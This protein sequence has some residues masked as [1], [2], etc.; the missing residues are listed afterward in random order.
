MDS[1]SEPK[2][3]PQRVIP[4]ESPSFVTEEELRQAEKPPALFAKRQP[5]A[6]EIGC[7]TGDF[8]IEIARCRPDLNFLAVDI[9]N[10]GCLK[11]CRKIDRNDLTNVRVLRM[12]ACH[13]LTHYLEPASL[14]ALYINCPDPW[15][16]KRHRQRRLVN[17]DFILLVRRS[18]ALTG[19]LFF[20]TDYADYARQVL[21]LFPF[22]GYENCLDQ[23]W[24]PHLEGY[25]YSKYMRRF[26]E[27]GQTLYF[28]HQRK[29]VFFPQD[30]EKEGGQSDIFQPLL[31]GGLS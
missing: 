29:T 15:P 31:A 12:E 25:P 16:K 23:P 24:A 9:Y 20:C 21:D 2:K 1:T 10:K 6:M 22:P 13:L 30:G 8:M 5:M 7:G 18:L 11:T 28:I 27:L 14:Q 3:Q 26:S 17:R 4:I 19:E